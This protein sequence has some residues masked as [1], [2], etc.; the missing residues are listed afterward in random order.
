MAPAAMTTRSRTTNQPAQKASQKASSSKKKAAPRAPAKKTTAPV[1]SKPQGVTKKTRPSRRPVVKTQPR[2]DTPEAP[3]S[4]ASTRTVS[5]S[6]IEETPPPSRRAR[7]DEHEVAAF[8]KEYEAKKSRS[9]SHHGSH[10]GSHHR[11]RS[12]HRRHESSSRSSSSDS[13]E[14]EGPRVSFIHQEGNKPFLKL[15]ERFRA[16]DIKYFKQIFYGTFKPKD[17][18]KLAYDYT[19]WAWS[20]ESSKDKKNKGTQE[21]SGIN[22]LLRG[23]DVYCQAIC[24]FAARPH[25]ALSLHEALI[26][27]RIRLSDFSIHYR[28]DSIRQYHYSFMSARILNGQDDPIAWSTESMR[29]FNFLIRKNQKHWKPFTTP[30]LQ[31]KGYH[32]PTGRTRLPLPARFP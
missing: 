32:K 25:V 18:L 27:Y 26:D 23:F 8:L 11:S 29:C 2:D 17:L 22:Q 30:M 7:L 1:A 31:S 13:E 16:V 5:P 20:S 6:V 19:D 12:H 14:G 9:R 21:A 3:T 10:H 15:H 24:Y 28:F 4:E